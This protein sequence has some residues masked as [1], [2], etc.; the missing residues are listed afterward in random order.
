[1]SNI[2]HFCFIAGLLVLFVGPAFLAL[3]L[4]IRAPYC[5]AQRWL[6][7]RMMRRLVRCEPDTSDADRAWA[8]EHNER[9]SQEYRQ[10]LV[11]WKAGRKWHR[12]LRGEWAA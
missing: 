6:F 11:E 5:R 8:R 2:Q 4:I 12:I 3:D 10:A 1:M 9:V 7:D